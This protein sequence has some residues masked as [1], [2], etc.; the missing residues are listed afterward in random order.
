MGLHELVT[1]LT[2]WC[3]SDI[4]LV[5]MN[6]LHKD[7]SENL[8]HKFI[9]GLFGTVNVELCRNVVVLSSSI[10]STI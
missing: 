2:E 9:N 3:K 5:I 1:Q 10:Y 4:L 6:L 8:K 7:N